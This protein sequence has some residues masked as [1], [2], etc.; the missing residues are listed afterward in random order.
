MPPGPI[1]LLD[2]ASL[3]YR[4]FYALPDSMRAPDGR[5]HQ[6]IRGFLTMLDAFHSAYSPSGVVA[7]WDE[8][9]RPEWRV[10]LMPSYKAHRVAQE[11][12]DGSWIEEEPDALTPQAEALAA[13]LDAA[14]I[15]R[16]GVADYEADDVAAT[17]AS[18]LA[19]PIVVVSGDRDLV[20]LVDDAGQ[21]RVLLAVNGGMSKWPLLDE[22]GVLERFGVAASQYVD[23]A[24]MRGD[25]SDGI[26]GVPGIGP[27][28]AAALLQQFGSLDA[29]IDAT[30]LPPRAPLTARIQGLLKEHADG[31][32]TARTVA[33]AAR[34]LPIDVDPAMPAAPRD[35]NA[36][37]ELLEQWGVSRFLPSW[38]PR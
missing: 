18:R 7:C 12:P 9:W 2:S 16:I 31:V 8:D 25:P 11:A 33:T 4:S 15:P 28:T 32:R 36:L 27:K 34:D 19:G 1:L 17:L 23:Y 30:S 3:Y 29:L 13:I 20:Q 26:P 6:A 38:L 22:A 10:E 14:G 5:P 21:V 24:V 37:T 35:A